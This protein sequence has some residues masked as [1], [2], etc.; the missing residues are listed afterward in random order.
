MAELSRQPLNCTL[1][2]LDLH[3][4][5][6]QA[7]RKTGLVEEKITPEGGGG[8]TQGGYDEGRQRVS[9]SRHSRWRISLSG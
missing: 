2:G 9:T 4:P 7:D 5:L 3:A 1:A 8:T 6:T